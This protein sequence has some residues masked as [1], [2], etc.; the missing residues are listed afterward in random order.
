MPPGCKIL[1][2]SRCCIALCKGTG[3]VYRF[4]GLSVFPPPPF[5]SQETFN[6]DQH[7]HLLLELAIGGELYATY[8]KKNLWGQ[9]STDLDSTCKNSHFFFKNQICLSDFDAFRNPQ[10]ILYLVFFLDEGE[11]REILR[12]GDGLCLRAPAREENHLPRSEASDLLSE[13]QP[14]QQNAHFVFPFSFFSKYVCLI[15]YI[16]FIHILLSI[17]K[18]MKY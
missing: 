18:S 12:G 3:T 13:S 2:E 6:S 16:F 5:F 7:L 4:A 17:S 8:N 15:F 11:M 9:D 10:W 14:D 1:P